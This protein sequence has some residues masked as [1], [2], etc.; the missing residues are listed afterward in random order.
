MWKVI[1]SPDGVQEPMGLYVIH[2]DRRRDRNEITVVIVVE[3]PNVHGAPQSAGCIVFIRTG[4]TAE[5]LCGL[6][7]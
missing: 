6:A 3:E 5:K 7:I 4:R 1:R 2:N